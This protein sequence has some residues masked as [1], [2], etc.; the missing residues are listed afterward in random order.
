MEIGYQS[1]IL[2]NSSYTQRRGWAI[3]KKHLPDSVRLYRVNSGTGEQYTR[4]NW[5]KQENTLRVVL[6]EFIKMRASVV[7]NTA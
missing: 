3:I 1:I 7:Y 2:V 4:E 5:Y 6:N